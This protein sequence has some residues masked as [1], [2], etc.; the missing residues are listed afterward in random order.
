MRKIGI[1]DCDVLIDL[2]DELYLAD[3]E[4][5]RNVVDH[6]LLLFDR[7]WIPA[8]VKEEFC[9]NPSKEKKMRDF[10][11]KHD[12]IDDCPIGVGES[13]RKL[14][15]PEIDE[16]E[17]DGIMQGKCVEHYERYRDCVCVFISGD[18]KA[19]KKGDDMG[20]ETKY[21]WELRSELM[22]TGIIKT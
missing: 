9:R 16:G 7:L 15:M 5:F 12:V 22:R 4:S 6:M 1:L 14:L 8:K 2:L 17:A 21:Y 11:E 3:K 20:I 18:K 19:N 13:D 10:I